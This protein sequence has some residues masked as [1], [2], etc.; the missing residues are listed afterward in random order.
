MTVE[1][2]LQVVVDACDEKGGY[3]IVAY[4]LTSAGFLYDYSVICHAP[5][6]RQ[7][8]AIA[9]E[10]KEKIQENGGKILNIEGWREAKWILLD[11]G[12]IIVNIMT[13]DDREYY[14]LDNLFE[15]YPLKDI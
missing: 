9:S 2:L 6:N 13:R 1:K 15:K 5:T 11:L 10:V 7:I 14:A 4:D 8:E 3:D 12:D